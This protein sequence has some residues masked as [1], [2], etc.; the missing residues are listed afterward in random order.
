[1]QPGV[2][3]AWAVPESWQIAAEEVREHLCAL[4]GGALFLSAADALLLVEWL[5]AGVSVI[6]VLRALERAAHARRKSRSKVP[7]S[8]THA[9]RHLGRPTTGAFGAT[10]TVDTNPPFSPA[11]RALQAIPQPSSALTELREQLLRIQQTGEPGLRIAL[12]YV[13][14]F[15]DQAWQDLGE[16]GQ[17]TLR[18]E[19]RQKLGDLVHLVDE[20]TV[21]ALV[22]EGARDRLHAQFPSLSVASLTELVGHGR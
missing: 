12:Q 14:K 9:R 18:T 3:E 4:R 21:A 5:E 22:E 16:T 10:A 17:A 8:L 7:L 11:A 1:M 20:T 6:D 15:L 13:R 19:A 2:P